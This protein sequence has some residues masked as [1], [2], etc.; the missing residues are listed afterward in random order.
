M[1]RRRRVLI[2]V[3][4]AVALLLGWLWMTHPTVDPRLIGRWEYHSADGTEQALLA[5]DSA[6]SR[7][8]WSHNNPTCNHGMGDFHWNSDGR[9]IYFFTPGVG[10][11]LPDVVKQSFQT[12]S[13][14]SIG[15]REIGRVHLSSMSREIVSVETQYTKSPL[16]LRRIED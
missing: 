13:G 1:S 2:A 15:G 9:F 16:F 14:I 10:R 5:L 6:G 11:Y 3:A 4:G 12:L 8:R 7:G